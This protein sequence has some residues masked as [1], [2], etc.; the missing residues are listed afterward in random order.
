MNDQI[1]NAKEAIFVAASNPKVATAVAAGT[2]STGA[3]AQLDLIT[4]IGAGVSVWIG[5]ATAA[6]VLAIQII[7]LVRE[8]RSYQQEE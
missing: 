8:W 3:A 6:V 7:K 5:A 4:G 1:E 2:A